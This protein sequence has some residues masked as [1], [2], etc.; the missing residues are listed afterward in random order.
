MRK[1][2]CC[3]IPTLPSSSSYLPALA[4]YEDRAL[5]APPSGEKVSKARN[6]LGT[7]L[8]TPGPS[9]GYPKGA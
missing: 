3:D 7:L 5:D 8:T 1:S 2:L 9:W 4:G 6:K